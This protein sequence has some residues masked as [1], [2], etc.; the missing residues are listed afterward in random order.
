M[1][2]KLQCFHLEPLS[3]TCLPE[4]FTINKYLCYILDFGKSKRK[5]SIIEVS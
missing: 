2:L 5:Y 4:M 1:S 3:K